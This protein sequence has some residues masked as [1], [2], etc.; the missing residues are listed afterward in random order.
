MKLF[1]GSYSKTAPVI[2][3]G[4]YALGSS[5]NIFD[6]LFA[7][8]DIEIA[9]SHGNN[10]HAYIVEDEKIA[11]SSDLDARFEEVHAFLAEE[12]SIDIEDVTEIAD[13]VMFD[14]DSDVTDFAEILSPRSNAFDGGQGDLSWELQRLR[15]RVAAHLGFDAVEMDD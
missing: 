12:L 13:R 5:D 1:H 11:T 8:A 7:S 14:N 15:G 4:A 2:K 9:S 10:A 3:V 6:G